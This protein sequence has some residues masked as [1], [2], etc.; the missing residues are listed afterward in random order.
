MHMLADQS[1]PL[2]EGRLEHDVDRL[3]RERGLRRYG[4]FLVSGEGRILPDGSENASGYVVDQDGRVFFFALDWDAGLRRVSFTQW[5]QVDAAAEADW[6]DDPEFQ[7][8][9]KAAGLA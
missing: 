6:D 5:E 4:L 1:E 8:A 3:I 9:R 2:R 7:Q